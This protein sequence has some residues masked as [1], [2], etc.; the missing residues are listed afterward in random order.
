MSVPLGTSTNAHSMLYAEKLT[1]SRDGDRKNAE[2]N[3]K[4]W[5][6]ICFALIVSMAKF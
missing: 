3:T 4:Q 1:K 2:K 6:K 5:K